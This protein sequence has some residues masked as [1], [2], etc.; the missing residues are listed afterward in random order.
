[1]LN[2][3]V[4][5]LNLKA[6]L[7]SALCFSCCLILP[8]QNTLFQLDAEPVCIEQ[9]AKGFFFVA[10]EKGTLA[11]YNSSGKLQ[12]QVNTKVYGTISKI[13]CKNPFEVYTY[14]NDQNVVVFYDNMLNIKGSLSLNKY[15]LTNVVDVARSFDNKLWLFDQSDLKLKKLSKSG[16]TEFE[17]PNLSNILNKEVSIAEVRESENNIFL[18]DTL[19]GIHVFDAF[20]TFVTTHYLQHRPSKW[21]LNGKVVVYQHGKKLFSYHTQFRDTQPILTLKEDEEIIGV[22][23]GFYTLWQNKVQFYKMD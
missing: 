2:L 15:Y 7:L 23:Q 21:F 3:M 16:T 22:N 19:H 5:R 18:L 12:M 4:I 10:D 9:D 13:D 17:S 6:L 8:A 11:K 1:M 20:G 14:H